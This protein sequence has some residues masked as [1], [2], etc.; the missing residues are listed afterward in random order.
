MTLTDNDQRQDVEEKRK[1]MIPLASPLPEGTMWAGQQEVEIYDTTLRDGTQAESISVSVEGKLRIAERLAEFGVHYIEGGWPGSNPKDKEFFE[2]A[3]TE[4]SPE[5]RTKLTAFGSTRRKFKKA[6]EDSQI[7][8]LVDSGVDCICLVG[9]SSDFH[10]DKILEV[11]REENLAMVHDSIHYLKGLGKEVMLDLEHFIDGFKSNPQYSMSVCQAAVDAGVDVLVMCDTNGGSLPWEVA[12]V[13]R[14]VRKMFPEVRLG[15]HCHNDQELAVANTLEAVREGATVVQGTINGL[16]ERTG[17]ANLCS[18]IPNL[19]LKMGYH[20]VG[21]KLKDLTSVSRFSDELMNRSPNPA[22]PFVGASAFAH[23]GGIHVS[24]IAKNPLSYQHIEPE[25]VGNLKRVLVSE[26]AGRS[27]I[28][29]KVEEYGLIGQDSDL[30]VWKERSVQILNKVKALEKSGYTF[31]GAEASVNL[32]LRRSSDMYTPPFAIQDYMLQIWDQDVDS[33][34]RFS[35][36]SVVEPYYF[37]GS[38]RATVKVLVMEHTCN[39]KQLLEVAEGNGPVNALANALMKGLVPTFPVLEELE[40]SDYKVR[41]LDMSCGKSG[42]SSVVRVM[43]DFKKSNGDKYTTVGADSNIISASLN[44]LVD[45]LEY[46]LI[47]ELNCAVDY[48]TEDGRPRPSS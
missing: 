2:R 28:M 20:G 3:K 15:I 29:T 47:G 46:A 48:D 4:L 27:N 13:T 21:D 41:I 45:G 14:E 5:A 39:E 25:E 30:N 43:M 33:V 10:V 24:A 11:P 42:T 19:Q 44:A 17:N 7:A 6:A 32:M 37:H 23:K 40:L 22:A 36:P 31:E 8:A 12:H 35:D 1:E 16:G 38:A 34:M 26:L 18:V 9:K